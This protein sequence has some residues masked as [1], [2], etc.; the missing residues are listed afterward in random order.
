MEFLPWASWMHWTV[1][2]YSG[3]L[4]IPIYQP[5]EVTVDSDCFDV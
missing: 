4:E 2:G 1:S 5:V 3:I